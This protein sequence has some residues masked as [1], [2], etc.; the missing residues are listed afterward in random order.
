M[1]LLMNI[2]FFITS[3]TAS[4]QYTY[5]SKWFEF[6]ND[7]MSI[8]T[9]NEIVYYTSDNTPQSYVLEMKRDPMLMFYDFVKI[10]RVRRRKKYKS[11]NK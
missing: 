9:S 4:S 3:L 8:D 6:Y 7:S 2:L 10:R 1:K 11:M 5:W